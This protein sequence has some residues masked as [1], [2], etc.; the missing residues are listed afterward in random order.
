LATF[1]QKDSSIEMKK[2]ILLIFFSGS[3]AFS[4]I[5]DNSDQ[6]FLMAQNY[7]QVFEFE[8]ANK[9]YL[10]LYNKNNHNYNY[11][12][13]F[14]RT[15]LALKNYDLVENLAKKKISENKL[16]VDAFG[17]L[18]TVFHRQ[19]KF[20]QAD[21]IWRF[22]IS[23]NPENE[24]IY[25]TIAN[26]AIQNR[27]FAIAENILTSG[28]HKF[29]DKYL[30]SMDLAN[31]FALNMDYEKAAI[32]YC[33][34]LENDKN[35]LS[36]VKNS[37][38]RLNQTEAAKQQIGE[39]LERYYD[40]NPST[41]LAD[42]LTSY[43]L[44]NSNFEK[45]FDLVVQNDAKR[46]QAGQGIYRFAESNLNSK[47]YKIAQNAY[48]YLIDNFEEFPFKE[49]VELGLVKSQI[50]IKKAK[51]L[52]NEYWKPIPNSFANQIDLINELAILS[53]LSKKA[54]NQTIL[55]QSKMILAEISTNYFLDF[56]TSK[57]L[58][59]E[60]IR[61][62]FGTAEYYKSKLNLA[63]I[64]IMESKF[65]S[66]RQSLKEIE[67]T[68][69]NFESQQ[70]EA[71]YLLA[72]ITFWQANFS[73]SLVEFNKI[74]FSKNNL[75]ANDAI[76]L[77]LLISA[78]KK[79]SVNLA[80][81]ARA[82]FE[83]FRGNFVL[84][85]ELLENLSQNKKLFIL[86][87]ISELKLIEI[88]IANN[89]MEVAKVRLNNILAEREIKIFADKPIL[90]LGDIYFYAEKNYPKAR[91]LYNNFLEKHSDSLYLN[92]VRENIKKLEENGRN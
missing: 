75:Y 1:S 49:N 23:E 40:E 83:I 69:K 35:K 60:I 33:E 76:S 7:E 43:Y 70:F 24:N 61:I 78:F 12:N 54:K 21:S 51:F 57:E 22:V 82:D 39:V 29:D 81:Y 37:I 86:N 14:V 30:F 25:R 2:T 65:E 31:L 44:L 85:T 84:A 15:S 87:D 72:K 6:L 5:R 4:Q 92:K 18:G 55:L 46:S 48:Q 13:G 19:G 71:S 9:L 62:K 73:K 90:Y 47:N 88:L 89:K 17:I 10:E 27:D 16:D 79:D 45:A 53:N 59:N 64:D 26:Y 32:E 67:K 56:S 8:K 68:P 38:S 91:D 11:F 36:Y 42:L 66:A 34:I 3:I 58:Y 74:A 50:E 77:K 63:K 28:K 80:N 41:E 52:E 20:Q